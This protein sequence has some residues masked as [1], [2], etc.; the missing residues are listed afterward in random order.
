[1]SS[2]YE[3]TGNVS[4]FNLFLVTIFNFSLILGLLLIAS[5]MFVACLGLVSS[6][7]TFMGG[8]DS[9]AASGG[10]MGKRLADKG[11]SA[12]LAVASSANAA[13]TSVSGG[14]SKVIGAKGGTK[15]K[16]ASRDDRLYRKDKKEADREDYINKNPPP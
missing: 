7:T 12:A 14:F 5:Q 9:D 13:V 11:Q 3:V 10:D 16:L 1:M 8:Q 15:K 4:G 6:A 2:L